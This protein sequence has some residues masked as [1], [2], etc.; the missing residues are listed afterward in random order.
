MLQISEAPPAVSPSAALEA[1]EARWH[2]E[3]E[4]LQLD[5][6]RVLQ[7]LR[8]LRAS[9]ASATAAA[10]ASSEPVSPDSHVAASAVSRTSSAMSHQSG[11]TPSIASA[12]GISPAPPHTPS[13]SR[14]EASSG[15]IALAQQ[16]LTP[17]MPSPTGGNVAQLQR[18]LEEARAQVSSLKVCSCGRSK[19]RRPVVHQERLFDLQED[20][21]ASTRNRI[22][23][24]LR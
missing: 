23:S 11:P 19:R 1:A 14:G 15:T 16:Q 6:A 21:S 20:A 9:L 2:L 8:E 4:Q 7:E 13:I 18:A 3:R 5:H 10:R 24:S 17:S 12:D 22:V